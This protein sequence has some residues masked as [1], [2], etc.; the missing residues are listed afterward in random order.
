MIDPSILLYTVTNV[1]SYNIF[2]LFFSCYLNFNRIQY[3]GHMPILFILSNQ[4]VLQFNVKL[5]CLFDQLVISLR[6]RHV[7]NGWPSLAAHCFF[8]WFR[9]WILLSSLVPSMNISDLPE[10]DLLISFIVHHGWDKKMTIN[11]PECMKWGRLH[12]VV[13]G[14]GHA[15]RPPGWCELMSF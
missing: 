10:W 1:R 2:I 6:I 15:P 12:I 13:G 8:R 4:V 14:G 7:S 3:L 11:I 5:K 9:L